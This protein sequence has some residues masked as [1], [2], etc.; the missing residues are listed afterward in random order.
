LGVSVASL[1]HLAWAQVVARATGQA[2]AVFGTVLFGRMQGGTGADR[3]LGLFINTLPLRVEVD[4][5]GVVDSVRVV[6]QRLAALLRH[7]HAPLSL[8]QQCSGVPAPAPLFTSLLNYRHSVEAKEAGGSGSW[9]GI[10]TLSAQERTNYPLTVSVDDWGTGFTL[11][12]Q[13]QRPLAP[14]RIAAFLEKALEGLAEALVHAPATAVNAVDVLPQDECDQVLR[15]WN[16]TAADYPRQACVH[17]LFEA[18][19]ARDPSAIAVVQGEVWLSY[20][21]LNARANRL[22]HHLR[23]LGVG[24]DDRVAICLERSVEMVVAVLAVLKAGGAYVPL[25]PAYPSER[26]RYMLA[27]AGAVVVLT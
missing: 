9:E 25:D 17:E 16:A 18:Q 23:A 26:L 6:Q 20:G 7:E 5:A 1:F 12:V 11:K 10:Q 22:A 19:V 21:V 27:D 2:S 13:S 14:A 24:A 15:Q 4:G 8:A 3:A